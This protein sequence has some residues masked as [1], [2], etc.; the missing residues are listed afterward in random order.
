M[1]FN[2]VKPIYRIDFISNSD[3][4]LLKIYPTKT[5]SKI[6]IDFTEPYDPE[7]RWKFRKVH[8]FYLNG[9]LTNLINNSLK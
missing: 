6:E 4:L 7:N 5:K 9:E 2:G 8:R 3:T 1:K